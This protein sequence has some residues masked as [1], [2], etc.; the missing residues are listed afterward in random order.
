VKWYELGTGR[1]DRQRRRTSLAGDTR[2]HGCV[3]EDTERGSAGADERTRIGTPHE[4]VLETAVFSRFE[5]E[6]LVHSV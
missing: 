1:E 2:V 3:R 5:A 6:E 4:V